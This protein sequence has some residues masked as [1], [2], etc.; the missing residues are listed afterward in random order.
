MAIQWTD[1][2]KAVI[3]SRNRN[4]LVSAAAGSGK[5][6]VLVERI[7]RMIT[8]GEEPAR[9]DQLLVMTFTKA[10]ADEMR[11]RVLKAVD[12]KLLEDPENPHLQMQAAMIP[13][14]QITTIDSFCLGLIREHYDKLD[15]DPAFRV[16]DQGELIL[17][18]ADVMKEMLEDFYEKGENRFEQ[19]VET[20]A[21][22]KTDHGI[23]DYIM[24]VYTFSQSN[25]WPADWLTRCRDEL[26]TSDM[27][28]LM[29]TEWMKFLMNDA[30]LQ[31]S[32]FIIQIEEAAGMC[33]EENGPLAYL[34]MLTSDL[35]LLNG[36]FSAPDY[37]KLNERLKAVSF[38]RLASIRSKDIDP[39][40]KAFVTGI[41]DRVKKAITKLTELYCFESP[42]E[43]LADLEGTKEAVSMLLDLAGEFAQRY[44]EKKKEK[45]LVDFNDLEHYALGILLT[46]EDGQWI[47]SDAADELSAQFVEILVDEYQ[48]SNDVQE[49]LINSISRERFG[50]PNVFMVGDVKQSI[51]QFRL[52]RPQLFLDKYESYKKEEGDYQKIELHQNFRSRE[53]VLKSINE[54]FYQVMT[55]N[56]GNISYTKDTALHPGADYAPCE[57]RAGEKSE[58]LMIHAEG[59]ALKEMDDDAG[60]FT[61][62]ELEAKAIAAKIRELIQPETGLLIWDKALNGTGGY[63]IAGYGD[64]VILLRSLSGWAEDFVNVLMNEG[65]PAYAETKTGYFTAV[66]VEVVLSML[67]I[68]DNPM[69]DIPLAAVLKSPLAGITDEEM[70][71]ITA[72]FKKKSK[73]GQDKGLYGAWMQYLREHEDQ[74]D[75]DYQELPGKLRDFFVMLQSYREKAA[76]L[77]IHELLYDLYEGTGYYNY[78]SAMPAGEV[79][80]ANLAMLVEKASAYEKTSY[81]GLFHFIRYIENLKKYD[82]DFGEA[83]LAGEEDTVRIMSIHKSKGLEF[84]VVFLAGMGKK[85]NKQDAYG[86]ILIDPDLGIGTDHLD[87]ERRLKAPTLK[88]HVLKRKME[89]SAMGEELRVL[90]VAMTRAKEKLIMTGLDR[91]LDKKMDRF[92]E[93]FRTGGQIP[94]TILSTADSYLDWLLM[95]LSGKYSQTGIL[96]ENGQD[97]GSVVVRMLSL[98]QLIGKE[99]ERQAAKKLTKD[100]LLSLDTEQVYD[101]SYEKKLKE[102]FEYQYPYQSDIGLHTKLSVS[103]L[104]KQGQFVDDLESDFLP[105]IP[106]FLREEET[107]RKSGGA[108]LGTAYHRVLELLDFAAVETETELEKALNLFC[109]EK[110]MKEES[111]SSISRKL[112]M[113][114]LK[115]PLG[116]RLSSA[117]KEGRLKKEQQFVIGIPAREMDLLESEE[118][119]LIQGIIDAYMEEEDGL[120]LVDYKTDHIKKGEEQVLVDRYQ[121]QMDYYARALEQMTGKRVKQG[122]I[123]SLTLQKEIVVKS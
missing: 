50:T 114:F 13:Y 52:A 16:A 115:S 69:Q 97:T 23:E 41:R 30:R 60:D 112:L 74:E 57:G 80:R 29:D 90:Y 62:R 3:E 105:T 123:Y 66:E 34:P 15:I 85:F 78:I 43:V 73:K 26:L 11:E 9:I 65:I 33:E 71:H 86:K 108:A 95:S 70:A 77:S 67:N 91:Y 94:F 120:V 49:A 92:S 53:E 100:Y 93:V 87:L 24:Q 111:L 20:Y 37:E 88:K 38:D 84:P 5:T 113:N 31:I 44:Q 18:K 59:N 27:G 6:A 22:G 1:E 110:K 101:E 7:I 117:Q 48:D 54:V 28:H 64:V 12:E 8:E 103:E 104:K 76:Y 61:S 40:K 51:Y 106:E 119:I 21:T 72:L 4:L 109:E 36:L 122:I 42:K 47:P 118:L 46:R 116:R 107:S 58:L 63:R 79:R 99:V 98:S 96:S 75:P 82:T 56:L 10:A 83:S 2:Q 17:L 89:L 45:N 68:I 25:P 55:K 32:E 19:F 39:E 35:R 81:T 121:V 102:A 14:A